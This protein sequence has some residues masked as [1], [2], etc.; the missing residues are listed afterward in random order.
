MWHQQNIRVGNF[1]CQSPKETLKNKQKLPES[2]LSDPGKQSFTNSESRESQI[3]NG[4]GNLDVSNLCP[5]PATASQLSSNSEE[6]CPSHPRG[7]WPHPQD[8]R[9]D[10]ICKPC[11]FSLART[12]EGPKKG[13]FQCF[14]ACT[15]PRPK[16]CESWQHWKVSRKNPYMFGVN[17]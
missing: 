17:F 1:K 9:A 6:S 2:S 8:S 16:S 10:L 5:T 11:L 3:K 7:V 14:L 4:R 13:A 12:P 15:S